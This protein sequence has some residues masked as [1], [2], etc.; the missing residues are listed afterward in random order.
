MTDNTPDRPLTKDA[1]DRLHGN[2]TSG[3]IISLVADPRYHHDADFRAAVAE[4]I[5]SAE[6]SAPPSA[7]GIERPL[8]P[9]EGLE[10]FLDAFECRAA[11]NS[12]RYRESPAYRAQVAARLAI[13]DL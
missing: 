12:P 6:F 1:I 4:R 8:P 13:S 7:P 11:M 9:T 5:A 10:P 2:N 3:E